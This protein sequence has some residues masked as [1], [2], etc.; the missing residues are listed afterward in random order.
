MNWNK[1]LL[2]DSTNIDAISITYGNGYYVAVSIQVVSG[3]YTLNIMYTQ[4]PADG[5][6]TKTLK[7]TGVDNIFTA[8]IAFTG[9]YFVIP[10]T[11]AISHAFSVLVFSDPTGD[12]TDRE[13]IFSNTLP[14]TL[15]S[16]RYIGS[17]VIVCGTK[18]E[19]DI[20]PYT[21]GWIWY[22]TDPTSDWESYCVVEYSAETSTTGRAFDAA[23]DTQDSK[24][25][26]YAVARTNDTTNYH[27]IYETADLATWHTPTELA[28]DTLSSPPFPTLAYCADYDALCLF[29]H[30]KIYISKGNQDFISI[31]YPTSIG[32]ESVRTA[33]SDG[34]K[35]LASSASNNQADLK[36]L[37]SDGDPV[38]ASNW[39][40]DTLSTGNQVSNSAQFING[41]KAFIVLAGAGGSVQ[42]AI[43]TAKFNAN[44][45]NRMKDRVPTYPGR[46]KLTSAGEAD[47]YYLERY[48][49][50][51]EE[52]TKLSKVNLLSDDAAL[53]VWNNTPPNVTCTPSTALEHLGKNAFHVGDIL[54]TVRDLSG[55]DNWLKCD[56]GDVSQTDYPELYAILTTGSIDDSW[57]NSTIST[58]D[59]QYIDMA[60]DGEWF[61]ILRY[62]GASPYTYDVLYTRDPSGVWEHKNVG[63]GTQTNW[64]L[65]QYVNG[66]FTFF[67]SSYTSGAS[68]PYK[69]YA[70][71][72][73]DPSGE[74]T[75]SEV[76]YSADTSISGLYVKGWTYADNKY[77][78]AVNYNHTSYNG[79]IGIFWSDTLASTL[80]GTLYTFLGSLST[81]PVTNYSA[82]SAPAYGNGKW[83]L[84][85]YYLNSVSGGNA[86]YYNQIYYSS[87]INTL[88]S[89]SLRLQCDSVTDNS[90]YMHY[91]NAL[92]YG[93]GFW[94]GLRGRPSYQGATADYGVFY[95]SDDLA[96]YT[97][98][99]NSSIRWSNDV[100][101]LYF[102]NNFMFLAADASA[103]STGTKKLLWYT[104]DPRAWESVT[105][106]D[107]SAYINYQNISA[108][109]Q[110]SIIF[111]VL[112]NGSASLVPVWHISGRSL[113]KLSPGVGLNAYIKAKEGD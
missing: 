62:L 44:E 92:V 112:R 43:Y 28:N 104:N 9:S 19:S 23:Y 11:T 3:T 61:V 95:S 74:W 79:S 45:F 63:T 113:P 32:T 64:T 66:E 2:S 59:P 35:F 91:V 57:R 56:G 29:L 72:T 80:Q 6:A 58:T 106:Y 41:T 96:S 27:R 84:S 30:G 76:W 5:W 22:C 71:H 34:T 87:D 81:N 97:F 99:P 52:G 26:I 107:G 42:P 36:V 89:S 85:I 24:Y 17:K 78:L 88:N 53:A 40:V 75:V 94:V 14:I 73:A 110:N 37:Y 46:I 18:S 33:T 12:I 103:G 54:T 1:S 86:Y 7:N 109:T 20:R 55:D 77:V 82:L 68:F 39:H 16:V 10:Y 67:Y 47:T 13:A 111:T 108:S 4:N 50:P 60:T 48:D 98:V 105:I 101:I 93:N 21:S 51:T 70:A 31:D 65:L 15:N 49:E 90:Q 8:G 83:A 69:I 38:V 25:N 100:N 102:E